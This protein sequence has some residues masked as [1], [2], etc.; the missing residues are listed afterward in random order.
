MVV[1]SLR[2]ELMVNGSGSLKDKRNTIRSLRERIRGKFNV[3]VAEVYNQDLWQRGTL[4]IAVVSGDGGRA[5]ETLD[6]V[7]RLI[8]QDMR[9]SVLDSLTEF[10]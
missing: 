10:V 3:S 1:A 4:G 8:E 2:V 7:L 5:R 9:V 6:K